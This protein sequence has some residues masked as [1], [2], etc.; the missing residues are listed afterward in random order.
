MC[1]APCARG[2]W[3]AAAQSWQQSQRWEESGA[4]ARWTP[5]Q[6]GR[7]PEPLLPASQRRWRCLPVVMLR[8]FHLFRKKYNRVA[9]TQRICMLRQRGYGRCPSW[10]L[11]R[12]CGFLLPSQTSLVR[13]Q[14][15]GLQLLIQPLVVT[16]WSLQVSKLG[17]P[18]CTNPLVLTV[19][20]KQKPFFTWENA[21][22]KT[23]VT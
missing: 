18:S 15:L 3:G 19:Q 16:S 13:Q 9:P 5:V 7:A 8:G 21:P 11:H 12:Q 2:G 23:A 10:R 17:G 14:R 22:E 1:G 6:P 20:D 4:A